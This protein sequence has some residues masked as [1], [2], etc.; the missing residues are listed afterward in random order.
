[1]NTA[2][3]DVN[4]IKQNVAEYWGAEGWNWPVKIVSA[5]RAQLLGAALGRVV[6][7]RGYVSIPVQ[8]GH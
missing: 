1:M 6:A 3:L 4:R 5:Q 7:V 8:V 2:G